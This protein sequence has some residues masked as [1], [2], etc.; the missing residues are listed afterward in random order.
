L[1]ER[2]QIPPTLQTDEGLRKALA[3]V[4]PQILVD[5]IDEIL[6]LQLGR[7]KGYRVTDDISRSGLWNSGKTTKLTDDA[8]FEAV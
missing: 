6:M 2:A 7:E 8:K 3:E 1:R 4:T 5:A